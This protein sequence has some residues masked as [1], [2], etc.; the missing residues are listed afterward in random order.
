[1][2]IAVYF[3]PSFNKR[4][5]RYQKKYQSIDSDFKAFIDN[6]ENAVPIDLG[7]GIYKYRLLVKSKNRG[8][9]GGFRIIT[10][11]VLVTEY[12]KDI[13]LIAIYDKS[14]LIS[15]SKSKITEI[16]KKEGLI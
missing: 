4:Y 10:F 8:K 3:T 7:G 15:I 13:T 1:M 2:R 11:E 6:L 5:K 16:L 9:S 12:D 14:E